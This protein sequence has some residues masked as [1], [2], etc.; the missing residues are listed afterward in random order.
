[1]FSTITTRIN[2]R[3]LITAVFLLISGVASFASERADSVRTEGNVA[4][5]KK[6]ILGK[7]Y[8]YFANSNTDRLT[9]R[10]N[11]TFIGGPSYSKDTKF[12]IGILSAGLYSTDPADTLLLPS[13]ISVVGEISTAGYYMA[14]IRGL[15]IYPSDSRRIN[16]NLKFSSFETYFWGIGFDSQYRNSNRT[17]YTLLNISLRS[18]YTWRLRPK[19]FVG[20]MI[21]VDYSK[22]GSV[23]N[24]SV[25]DGEPLSTL[26]TGLGMV[27]K[28][29]S[30]DNHNTPYTGELVELSQLFY[31]NLYGSRSRYFAITEF[32]AAVYRPVWRGG[33]VATRLHG[34][35]SFGKPLWNKL[36]R[37]GGMQG[38]RGYYDGRYRDQNTADVIVEL[39]QHV[40]R[41]SGVVVW[42]GLGTIFRNPADI[43]FRKLLPNIGIGYRWE[44]KQRTNV[45]LDYGIGRRESG[46]VFQINE[47][48]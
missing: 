27:V 24:P 20:P 48:F 4:F 26:A 14:G 29:D 2:V 30:R 17:S 38:M 40:W 9:R 23:E 25:W 42:G 28:Y 15:H 41:R 22:A 8:D 39:R 3:H 36:P 45:R 43:E 46:L 5:Y 10:P 12:S 32:S 21:D 6:G 11:F 35:F 44:F 18:D 34:E 31:P 19:L 1:M 7:V 16:Y 13:N 37:L 47:A 33:V